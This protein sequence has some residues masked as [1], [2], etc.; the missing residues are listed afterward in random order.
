MEEI[1]VSDG[2]AR[3]VFITYLYNAVLG[4]AVLAGGS[5]ELL[6]GGERA[7][8]KLCPGRGDLRCK[9]MDRIA[10]IVG[11][12][13][14]YAFMK[15]KLRVCLPKR[16]KKLLIAALIAADFEGDRA[17]VRGKMGEIGQ[18]SIDGFY[19][20]RLGALREKWTRIIDYIPEG[21]S[22]SDL[23]KFCEF[24]VGESKNKIY[25]KGN[26]VFG[27]NF[28]PLRRGIRLLP[29]RGGKRGGRFFAKILCGAGDIFLTNP[30]KKSTIEIA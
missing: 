7:A 23:L 3:S 24:L 16:E 4:D 12:G 14:K 1:V 9:V 29:R 22:S 15:E 26:V 30:E 21:F 17:F 20:F 6:F 28:A 27:E 11:I 25:V 8:V 13:Y 2:S 19:M 10:E 5:G 18:F